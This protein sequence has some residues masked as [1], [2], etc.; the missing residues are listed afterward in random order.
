M[1][2][3]IWETECDYINVKRAVRS[4]TEEYPFLHS[5]VIGKSVA[6]RDITALKIGRAEEYVLYAGA[7]HGSEHITANLLLK[8][9]EELCRALS[10]YEHLAGFDVRRIMTG[11]ALIIV[12]VVNPDGVEI[13][14][15]GTN[16]GGYMSASVSRLCT[17]DHRKWNANMRG[18]D[19]NHNFD[20][21]WESLRN[22]EKQNGIDGPSMTRF[23]GYKPE[24]E[25]ETLALV[26]LCRTLRIRHA[27][28][29][30]SQGEVIY[31]QYKGIKVPRA[32][33]MAEIMA[34]VTGY[35]LDEPSGLA[36]G[37]GF[38]DWFIKEFTR[39][40]FTVEIGCGEN[41]LP[42]EDINKI[43]DD[44]AEMLVLCLAM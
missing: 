4:L 7:F 16:A 30:H 3:K 34:S 21:G 14:I 24:S 13:S 2:K 32:E 9:T 23:G 15:H 5:E 11:R 1:S 35:T 22:L 19:I 18:V 39:P 42:T 28:A 8:F 44:L 25:P 41:P 40:G 37:G 43:Y 26:G 10:N 29:F 6:G 17:G 31:W 36:I 20:A 38:K 27:L 12:P 33:K